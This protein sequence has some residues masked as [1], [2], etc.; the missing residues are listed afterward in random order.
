M[1]AKLKAPFPY[2]GG[3]SAV[4]GEVW[5]RFGNVRNYVEP[6]FGSGAVLLGRPHWRPGGP[7]LVET[8]NDADGLLANFWRAMTADPEA[9]ARHA[10]WPVNEADLH[11]RHLWLVG[12]R[13]RITERL[14]GDP[15]WF[16]DKAAGWWVWGACGWIGSGWCSGKGP[17]VSD[18]ERLVHRDE[19]GNTGQG[20]N[21]QLPHMGN[22]GQGINRQL[23][24]MG[25]AGRAWGH[26]APLADRLRD[27]RVACG[28]WTRVLGAALR[29]FPVFPPKAG[30]DACGVFL[31]PPYG[32][33]FDGAYA[34]TDGLAHDRA[35]ADDVWA[36][37]CE[38]GGDPLLRVCVAGYDDG[39]EAPAGWSAVAW[40][41]SRGRVGGANGY[42]ARANAKRERL[43]FS[44]H[45]L[46]PDEGQLGLF[47]GAL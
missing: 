12:Q 37:A 7:R 32:E 16:D 1:A 31:D 38:R 34:S 45:C 15:E 23:P 35:I 25:N 18:G 4:A 2:F 21:R 14:M 39:R 43:W 41:S 9:V 36:W 26:L 33:G 19:L 10:E 8:V 20:I 44:P 6:F 47:G 42:G 40:D 17:W 5:R 13:E 11:A 22:S 27:V 24:H 3:K 28:D 29:A 46:K 30:R